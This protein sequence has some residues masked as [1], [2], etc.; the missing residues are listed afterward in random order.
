MVTTEEIEKAKQTFPKFTVYVCYRCGQ[1]KAK[2]GE[3]YAD[4]GKDY[5][6]CTEALKK[7]K[8]GEFKERQDEDL[9]NIVRKQELREEEKSD[10]G[11]FI[12]RLRDIGNDID[13]LLDDYDDYEE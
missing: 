10:L 11:N 8:E 9:F 12:E 6:A 3:H 4:L 13:N 5:Y 7:A 1:T 2:T